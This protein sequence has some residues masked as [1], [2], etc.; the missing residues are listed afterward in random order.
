LSWSSRILDKYG[1]WYSYE[2]DLLGM[3]W[4]VHKKI[5]DVMKTIDDIDNLS[6]ADIGCGSGLVGKE[7]GRK[8]IDGFDLVPTM[9]DLARNSYA[10]MRI[11]NIEEEPLHK[12]YDV[13]IM[14]G[15]FTDYT[16]DASCLQ[17]VSDS[18]EDDGVL[19]TSIPF[20]SDYFNTSGWSKQEVFELDK[21]T[22]PF[23]SWTPI[24]TGEQK[25]HRI[26]MW[27]KK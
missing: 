19:I 7:W 21:E 11:H 2:E 22:L 20:N 12:K 15:T 18:L 3:G 8:D 5:V 17:N 6:K 4:C 9:C 10:N 23:N 26:C 1:E 16:L 27:R 25:I 13:I 24:E 14:C